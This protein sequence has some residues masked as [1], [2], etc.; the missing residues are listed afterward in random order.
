MRGLHELSNNM[1]LPLAFLL[2]SFFESPPSYWI[3]S[4]NDLLIGAAFCGVVAVVWLFLLLV[5][6]RKGMPLTVP[7]N[8][9][10]FAGFAI[11]LVLLVVVREMLER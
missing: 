11:G 2:K 1:R 6:R 4:G 3:F 7:I 10:C 9:W 5:R 8:V